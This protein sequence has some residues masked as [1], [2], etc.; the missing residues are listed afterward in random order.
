MPSVLRSR[1]RNPSIQFI[2]RRA[3]QE[4]IILEQT[5]TF[6]PQTSMVSSSWP[7]AWLWIMSSSVLKH[8]YAMDSLTAS[9]SPTYRALDPNKFTLNLRVRNCSQRK[10][11]TLQACQ[12]PNTMSSTLRATSTPTLM[13]V[14][15][16]LGSSNVMSW[17]VEKELLS[18]PTE[19]RPL[20]S[21]SN[22]SRRM[23]TFCSNDSS[24]VK[25]RA[26]SS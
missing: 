4:R 17:L 16:I 8:R 26:C 2:R 6:P 14:Q 22:P 7:N 12:Q 10:Q 1:F 9:C 25:K 13:L 3:M 23:D 20:N 21:S 5:T 18:P 19:A 24:L 15:R 11:W